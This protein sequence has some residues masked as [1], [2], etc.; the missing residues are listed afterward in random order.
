MD[1]GCGGQAGAGR[2]MPPQC[3]LVCPRG[4]SSAERL[5]GI[6]LEREAGRGGGLSNPAASLAVCWG[7]PKHWS[8]EEIEGGP[9]SLRWGPTSAV[10][11]W[12]RHGPLSGGSAW[13]SLVGTCLGTW[14]PQPAPQTRCPR[15]LTLLPLSSHSC[16]QPSPAPC[17]HISLPAVLHLYQLPPT[18]APLHLLFPP[19]G[20]FL[21]HV[22]TR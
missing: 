4:C 22:S 6:V 19:P 16:A 7:L 18:S 20:R 13:G 2:N 10:L 9:A 5:A 21:P 8:V 15:R 3:H 11:L 17:S 1:T 14:E 12:L